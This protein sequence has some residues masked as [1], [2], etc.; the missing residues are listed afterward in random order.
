[1]GSG[2]AFPWKV[3][4]AANLAHGSIVEDM[5]LGLQL[6]HAGSP[7]LFCPA[8][9]ITSHFPWSDRRRGKPTH[10]LGGRPHRHDSDC[11][12]TLLLCGYF[13]AET[14][15]LAL[16]LDLIVPPLSLLALMVVGIFLAA[17]LELTALQP[18][19]SSLD[20]VSAV[21]LY[22]ALAMA[23]FLA[24]I[25]CGRDIL[26]SRQCV[27]DCLT[28]VLKSCDVPADFLGPL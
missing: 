24:W 19:S 14:A 4:R 6:A 8:A 25:K 27:F 5:K 13:S 2:M 18:G 3:I 7:P 15:L 1:M 11:D 16:T 17:G 26:P 10:A 28:M 20:L 22:V 23:A 21:S 9:K 12:A